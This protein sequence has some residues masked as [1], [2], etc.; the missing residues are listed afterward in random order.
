[1]ICLVITRRRATFDPAWLPDHYAFL[2]DLTA[3]GRLL[4]WGPFADGGGGGYL[5]KADTLAEGRAVA[6]RD[7]LHRHGCSDLEIHDWTATRTET[8]WPS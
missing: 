3:Q 6:E 5:L 7:P 4:L 2:A 8:P 1:M